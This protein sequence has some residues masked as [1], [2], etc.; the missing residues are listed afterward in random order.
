MN[1]FALHAVFCILSLVFFLPS[2]W[3]R[4]AFSGEQ[5]TEKKSTLTMIYNG[6]FIFLH[7]N[8]IQNGELPF[9]GETDTEIIGWVSFAMLFLYMYALPLGEISR[10]GFLERYL[11]LKNERAFFIS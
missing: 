8:F 11:K 6:M 7:L 9:I 4:L 1:N 10:T 2:L 5:Y 3:A